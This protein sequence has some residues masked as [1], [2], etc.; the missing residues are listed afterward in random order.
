MGYAIIIIL[1]VI[2]IAINIVLYR[3]LNKQSNSNTNQILDIIHKQDKE[4][5]EKLG[6]EFRNK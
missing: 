3:K 4:D 6:G 2:S 5:K 1:L